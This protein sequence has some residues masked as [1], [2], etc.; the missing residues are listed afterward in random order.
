MSLIPITMAA[1]NDPSNLASATTKVVDDIY[2]YARDF[3]HNASIL[4]TRLRVTNMENNQPSNE[5][6]RPISA[7]QAVVTC[8]L[9]F[10]TQSLRYGVLKDRQDDGGFLVTL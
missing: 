5:L 4:R 9:T 7:Y 8:V 6:D 2:A 10:S 3:D 1:S